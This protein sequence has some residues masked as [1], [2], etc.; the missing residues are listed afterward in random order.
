MKLDFYYWDMQ[1]PLNSRMLQL[2][3]KYEEHFEITKYDV[4]NDFGLAKQQRM[5][6]PTLT[7]VDGKQR[8]FAPLSERFF[9]TLIRGDSFSERPYVIELG[10]EG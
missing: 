7:V 10:W 5:F 3:D 8:C 1:C 6:F 2:L 9:E 4:A